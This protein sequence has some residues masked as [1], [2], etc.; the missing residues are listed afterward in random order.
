MAIC[1]LSELRPRMTEAL[2]RRSIPALDAIEALCSVLPT[3]IAGTIDTDEL[4][5]KAA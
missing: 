3:M 1:T 2:D 4:M 5:P